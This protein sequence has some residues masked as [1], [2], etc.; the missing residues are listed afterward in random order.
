MTL[1]LAM[2]AVLGP[3]AAP[4]A[5]GVDT[6]LRVEAPRAAP[7]R[8]RPRPTDPRDRAFMDGGLPSNPGFSGFGR[9]APMAPQAE[10]APRP[11]ND[12]EYRPARIDPPPVATIS[13]TLIN[14]AL[15][16]RSTATQGAINQREQRFLDNPAAG[17][18]FSVPMTW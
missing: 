18:R 3:A 9:P 5:Q 7:A 12:L 2:A 10:L 8:P 15:P 17:A 16:G 11:N 4:S 14:P 6:Q 1:V 13:P